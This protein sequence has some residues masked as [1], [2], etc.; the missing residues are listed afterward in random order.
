MECL[1]D[2]MSFTSKGFKVYREVVQ[3]V[4]ELDTLHM[5]DLEDIGFT[6]DELSQLHQNM[7]F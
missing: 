2:L 4:M 7:S 5:R 6:K 3:D 1:E